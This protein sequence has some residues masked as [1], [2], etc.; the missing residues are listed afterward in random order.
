MN[1]H[2]NGILDWFVCCLSSSRSLCVYSDRSIQN[3]HYKLL[4]EI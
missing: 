2:G 3:N 4:K 1:L